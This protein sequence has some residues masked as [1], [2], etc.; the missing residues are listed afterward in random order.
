[1]KTPEDKDVVCGNKKHNSPIFL[2]PFLLQSREVSEDWTSS[3]EEREI[4]NRN[5]DRTFILS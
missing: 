4:L 2:T 5:T 3:K 1:M